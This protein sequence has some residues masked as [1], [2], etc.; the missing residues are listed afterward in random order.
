MK[1][2]K[3]VSKRK[4]TKFHKEIEKLLLNWELLAKILKMQI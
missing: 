3:N 4:I 2:N 1:T